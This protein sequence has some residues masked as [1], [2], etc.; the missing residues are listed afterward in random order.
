MC[1]LLTI[2]LWRALGLFGSLGMTMDTVGCLATGSLPG[3]DMGMLGCQVTGR[4]TSLLRA[5]GARPTAPAT[6]GRQDII[7]AELGFLELGVEVQRA[8]FAT[9]EAP[10]VGMSRH[11]ADLVQSDLSAGAKHE[12]VPQLAL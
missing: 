12:L 2:D 6:T 7:M 5:S 4:R 1:G 11:E 8:P 10:T 3:L 9:A